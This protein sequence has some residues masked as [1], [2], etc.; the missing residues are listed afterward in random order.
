MLKCEL[1]GWRKQDDFLGAVDSAG[2]GGSALLLLELGGRFWQVAGSLVMVRRGSNCIEEGS[3]GSLL[4]G[5]ILD[6]KRCRCLLWGV[7][8]VV[9]LKVE[10]QVVWEGGGWVNSVEEFGVSSWSRELG[11][12]EGKWRWVLWRRFRCLG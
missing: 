6:G 10:S 2:G 12:S 1:A 4:V 8:A 11:N 9:G 5:W 7:R 3:G